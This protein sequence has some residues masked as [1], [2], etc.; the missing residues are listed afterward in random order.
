MRQFI[1]LLILTLTVLTVQGQTTFTGHLRDTNAGG[2]LVVVQS[3]EIENAVNNKVL[4]KTTPKKTTKPHTTTPTTGRDSTKTHH[5][6]EE[7]REHT[8]HHYD[9]THQPTRMMGYRIQ[10]YAGP[11]SDGQTMARRM[12]TRCRKAL[13]GLATYVKF[14]QPRWTCRVGD[15]KTRHDAEV[16]LRKVRDANISSQA[17]IVKSEIFRVY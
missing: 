5:E 8:T 11:R 6:S 3:S 13:P 17:T 1:S 10:I 14:I 4:G 2:R 16:F 12:A 9:E 15:F 7:P